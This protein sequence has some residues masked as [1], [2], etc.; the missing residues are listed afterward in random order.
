MANAYRTIDGTDNNPLDPTLGQAKG[1]LLR[2]VESD[3]S[4]DISSLAGESRPSPREIS[5]EIF[6]QA[7]SKPNESGFSDFL[8][9]WG[10]FLDHDITLSLTSELE[11]EEAPI[12]VPADDLLF[13]PTGSGTATIDF[14]RS[15]FDPLTGTDADNPRQQL[16]DITA[17]IDASN[18]YG[19]DS[20]RAAA[21]RADDGRMKVSD[22]DLMPFNVDGLPNAMG[23]SD[24]FFLGGDERANENVVLSSMHTL[25]LREHNRLV[26]EFEEANPGW[27]AETLY[28]EARRIVEAEM[29]AITYNEF[30]PKLIG[31]DALNAYDGYDMNVNPE[32]ANIFSTAAYRLGHTMLS[33]TVHRTDEDGSENEFGDLSLKDAFFRPDR[34]IDEGGIDGLLRG[35]GTS[36]AESLDHQIVDDVRNFL[37]GPPGSDGLD[38]AS[39]NIQR[40]RDHGLDDYNGA[41][42][43][44]GLDPVTTF[45]EI[46]SD[47]GL[48]TKLQD[49]FGT[50][51]D[52]DV[53]VGALAED[54]VP[55]S[56]VGELFHVALVDQFTRLRDGDS[57]WYESRLSDAEIAMIND[58]TLSDIIERNSGVET[59]QDDVFMALQRSA[60]TDDADVLTA[61]DEAYLL[62]GLDGDDDMM[63]SDA[64]GEMHG[65]AGS[66]RLF[67]FTANDWLVG[68]DE[69]DQLHGEAGND[70]LLGDAGDDFLTA[71]TGDDRIDGGVGNDYMVTGTGLDKVKFSEGQDVVEDFDVNQDVLDFSGIANVKSIADLTITSFDTG[72]LIA[73]ASG[74]NIWLS[75][76]SVAADIQMDFGDARATYT[77]Q[78]TKVVG[79]SA[80][81]DTIVDSAGTQYVFAHYGDD[82]FKVDG[83]RA[84]YSIAKTLDGTG[85]VMWNATEFDIFWDLEHVEFADEIVDLDAI[86]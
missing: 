16:N 6:S 49:L 35:A 30:L 31:E 18:V 50:V 20:E 60:G 4:D 9:I 70:V 68:G 44:Y 32:I 56:M 59:M 11:S 43:A 78:D 77:G 58:T 8:W 36:E 71:G 1:Q 23:T 15:E 38:L 12:P 40:G 66:D 25:F 3:Y 34:L 62:L 19:S 21:L 64:A 42:Q 28:Q 22:G 74:N 76:V 82:T 72:T 39:L 2:T 52:I 29:Q 69:A 27:D 83:A 84:D 80:G 47:V 75:G 85:Y 73:D 26:T 48:Q 63:A 67:G 37:F 61:G 41:R 10:Q 24:T 55:G 51:D 57:Y 13:D 45:A 65:G 7:E 53:F 79:T 81:D 86:V 5:N 46:T 17:Y 14:S 54:A 33:S